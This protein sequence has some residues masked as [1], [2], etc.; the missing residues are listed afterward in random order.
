MN[1]NIAVVFAFLLLPSCGG[2]NFV[3]IEQYKKIPACWANHN[4]FI[5][6]YL[7][8]TNNSN[9]YTPILISKK[10]RIRNID[11]S[12]LERFDFERYM[13][14]MPIAGDKGLMLREG[15]LDGIIT[16]NSVDHKVLP[17]RNSKVYDFEGKLR[18]TEFEGRV[19]FHISDVS[20]LVLI[21]GVSYFNSV[22]D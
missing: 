9:G 8:L 16:S 2:T 4:D 20:K 15:K 6:G 1:N 3:D 10:C 13:D 21:G 22:H 17:N 7:V 14:A 11:A 18:A 12:D 19:Y 5:E